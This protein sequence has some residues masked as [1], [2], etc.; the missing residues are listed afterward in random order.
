MNKY[1]YQR[2]EIADILGISKDV[3]RYY[4]AKNLIHPHRNNENRYR[5]YS[6][7]DLPNL[8]AIRTLRSYGFSMQQ[9]ET[10]Q[11]SIAN[12]AFVEEIDELLKKMDRE[13][14]L[15]K[16][17]RDEIE[18]MKKKALILQNEQDGCQILT[19]YISGWFIAQFDNDDYEKEKKSI[20]DKVRELLPISQYGLLI[21]DLSS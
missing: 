18:K 10:Q 5:Y 17:K 11:C 12:S 6:E 19:N 16:Q 7:K 3:L 13:I 9:M 21:H 2:G 8:I 20:I 4:E 14:I 15:L 1:V